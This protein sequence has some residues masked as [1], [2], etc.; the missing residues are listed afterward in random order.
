MTALNFVDAKSWETWH[1]NPHGYPRWSETS[2]TSDGV[3][4]H[5]PQ[6]LVGFK[7][8]T[9]NTEIICFF[10]LGHAVITYV[11]A[12]RSMRERHVSPRDCILSVSENKSL[13]VG[14]SCQCILS[15]H[16]QQIIFYIFRNLLMHHFVILKFICKYLNLRV[17]FF[18]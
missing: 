13:T 9:C 2:S 5:Q 11:D 10:P 3:S 4:S 12:N 16:N 17:T 1:I 6:A 7:I 18:Y 14:S 8:E 15:V